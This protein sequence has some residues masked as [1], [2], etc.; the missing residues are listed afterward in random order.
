MTDYKNQ[1]LLVD[2]KGRP[3]PQI[4]D[5]ATGKFYP[6]TRDVCSDVTVKNFPEKQFVEDVRVKAE[7]EQVKA[8][9]EGI[10][11]KLNGTINTQLT[12]SN[13]PEASAIPTRPKQKLVTIANAVAITNTAP[14]YYNLI[15]HGE[16]TEDEVRQY[17]RFK[18]SLIN[19]HDQ[20]ATI[21][22]QTVNRALGPIQLAESQVI[23]RETN[24]LPASTGRLVL[25]EKAVGEGAANNFKSIPA[26][27]DIHS[28]LIV[29]VAFTVAPTS[30]SITIVVEMGA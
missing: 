8:E 26:L 12:G 28:N 4:W 22:V 24:N 21:S 19:S 11:T 13:V 10:K 15:T 30:G 17:K 14:K 18:I 27:A 1:E 29:G 9:L 2:R 20:A 7:L 23:Y 16:L 6:L 25:Q 3:I 5:P